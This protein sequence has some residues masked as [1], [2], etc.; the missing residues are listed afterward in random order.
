MTEAPA[1]P[2]LLTGA[3]GNLGGMLASWLSYPDLARSVVGCV[4]TGNVGCRV[5]WP[6]PAIFGDTVLAEMAGS[7]PAMTV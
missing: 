2:V 4:T 6:D 7:G 3:S 1:K 5:V